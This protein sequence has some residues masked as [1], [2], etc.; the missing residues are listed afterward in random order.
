MR[1]MIL[2][3]G[4]GERMRP[5]TDRTP[6]SMLQVN[7]KPLIQYHV[8]NLV[9]SGILDIVINHAQFGDQIEGYLGNG[10]IWG[11]R[12]AYSPEDENPL[13]TAGGIVE[14]LPLLGEE[15]FLTVNADIWTDFPFQQLLNLSENLANHL[16][17]IVLVDN[18]A[19]NAKGD[20][21]LS[22]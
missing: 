5:L 20:F 21:S 1:A 10:K 19:H 12:I 8:E 16:A 2:A 22:D 11:A 4:R 13:D 18:P 14:A 6:K 7:G 17:H 15:P 9:Q 3:A